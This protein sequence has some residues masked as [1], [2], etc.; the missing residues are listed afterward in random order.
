MK[1]VLQTLIVLVTLIGFISCHKYPDDPFISLKRPFKRIEGTWNITSYQINGVEHSHN[2]DSLLSPNTLTDCS[3][4][5]VNGLHD[6]NGQ[7]IPSAGTYHFQNKNG[8]LIF[9][10]KYSIDDDLLKIGFLTPSNSDT[11]LSYLLFYNCKT[12]SSLNN[13]IRGSFTTNIFE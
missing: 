2:F 1:R 11:V 10:D 9:S 7:T 4:K 13:E 6:S 12:T 5:F 3:I 8:S